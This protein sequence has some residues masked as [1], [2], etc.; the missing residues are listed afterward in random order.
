MPQEQRDSL[1]KISCVTPQTLA[2]YTK[3]DAD[4]PA[5]IDTLIE[6]GPFNTE[7]VPLVG[8]GPEQLPVPSQ[9][10]RLATSP[11]GREAP[12]TP[13]IGAAA[14]GAADPTHRLK[15]SR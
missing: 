13:S 5:W 12:P 2:E 8:Q 10:S 6:N 7:P 14:A 15:D 1:F 11:P 3:Y 4:I 9:L